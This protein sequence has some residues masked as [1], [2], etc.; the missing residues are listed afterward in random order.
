MLR[1]PLGHDLCS[2]HEQSRFWHGR[3]ITKYNDASISDRRII[4]RLEKRKILEK[5]S[6][7]EAD[8]ILKR[9]DTYMDMTRPVLDFYSKNSNFYEIDGALKIEQITAKI[10]AFLNV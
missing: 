7:D 9:Y 6:D 1:T 10:D 3:G 5:R 2:C 4:K 8:T